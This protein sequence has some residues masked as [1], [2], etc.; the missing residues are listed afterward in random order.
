[1]DIARISNKYSF[2]SLEIWALDS[3]ETHVNRKPSIIGPAFLPPSTTVPAHTHAHNQYTSQT[4]LIITRLIRLAQMCGHDGLLNTMIALLRTRMVG[5]LQ[6]AYLAMTLADELDLLP[7][8]G[9][10]YLEVMQKANIVRSVPPGRTGGELDEDGKLL[11]NQSQ[12]FR[13]LQGYLH[14]THVW[15][16]LRTAPPQF[17]HSS[18]CGA[19]LHQHGCT[20]SW[21]EFWKEKVKSDE[22]LSLGAADVLGRLKQIQK[23]FN[24][25]GSATYMHPDCKAAARRSMGETARNV[26]ESLSDYFSIEASDD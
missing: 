2:K 16:R 1:M 3:L 25:W 18:S 13:L 12:R 14:L 7:L 17:D 21:L 4:P 10:A 6:Y 8:R 15:E 20:Q 24:R 9:A 26:E 22:C 19:T 23:D 5:S 11:V